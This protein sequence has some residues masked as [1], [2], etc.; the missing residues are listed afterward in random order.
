MATCPSD[1]EATAGQRCRIKCPPGFVYAAGRGTEECVSSTNERYRVPV[2]SGATTAEI[3]TA[4]TTFQTAF[5][6]LQARMAS[7]RATMGSLS[8][9]S[10]ENARLVGRLE[11]TAANFRTLQDVTDSLTPLRPPTQPS[12][13]IEK[14]RKL[15]LKRPGE[16]NLLVVQIA[17]F[18]VSL[19]LVVYLALPANIAHP[20]AF[21]ILSVGIAVGIFLNN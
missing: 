18:I 8:D 4:R 6:A 2:T 5:T 20:V 16:M 11:S 14:E 13:D 3:D 1:F 19:C 17:L 15:L 7:D 12:S 21:L 9:V 10:R